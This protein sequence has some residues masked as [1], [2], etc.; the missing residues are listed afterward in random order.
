[1]FKTPRISTIAICGVMCLAG[2]A[3]AAPANKSKAIVL[4]PIATV[5]ASTPGISA[6]E[7]VT[8]D[9]GTQRLFVVNARAALIDVFDI[10]DPHT[11]VLAGTIDVTPYGNVANSVSVHAGVVAVAIESDP[12]TAPG[13]VAFFTTDLEFLS[14]VQV[15]A[16]P[17]MITFTHNGQY[18]LTANEGE[19]RSY[20]PGDVDDPEGSISVINVSGGAANVTQ[21]NVRTA[22]F[23]GFTKQSLAPGIRI[24]G[25]GATVAQD[26]EPEYIATS[27]DSKT[28]WATLQENNALAIIDIP[29]ARVTR[30]VPLGLKNHGLVE[31]AFDASDRD[32]SIN[33]KAWPR[34]F[35]LYE[36]DAVAAYEVGGNT[37]LVM[38]NEGDVRAD[39]PGYTEEVRVGASSYVLDPVR[40]PDAAT[41]KANANLGRLKVSLA[42]G[43]LDGD[44]DFDEIHSYGG[45][46]FSIR[47]ADGTLVWDSGSQFET[48]IKELVPTAFNISNDDNTFDSRS[49]D[50]GPEP[51]GLTLGKVAGRTYAF[52]GLERIG[53][54]MVYDITNPASPTFVTYANNR[55]YT[56][57][58]I[59]L[60]NGDVNPN[61]AGDLGPEGLVFISEENSPN[62]KPLLIIANEVSGTTTVYE[63]ARAE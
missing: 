27:H 20:V 24:F 26:L 30:I 39:W 45:R 61:G 3:G 32:S 31:N 49:D 34:V 17:D 53:G 16:Q 21:A 40:F 19:P 25:P 2:A 57:A 37:Y 23:H 52:V 35:G 7:I 54:A 10:H 6:A 29:N 4:T 51:E 46:S 44:G 62:G 48:K 58:P 50:K 56:K 8:Y 33:I 63:I 5:N 38:A 28:A 42:S 18:V 9:P 41:L 11:P 22:D 15:G 14:V 55:D 59:P 47:A 36:S 12:K 1:M 13:H 43:D 60:S